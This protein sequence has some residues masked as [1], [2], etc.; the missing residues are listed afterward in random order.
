MTPGDAGRNGTRGLVFDVDTFAVHDGPGIRM[1]VYLKGCPL[2]C[3]WCHSPESRDP[4]RELV[5]YRDR[6]VG[7]G[8]CAGACPEHAHALDPERHTID[9][10]RCRACFA[11]AD[12]CPS[13]ALGVKGEL[14]PPGEIVARAARMRPFFEHSGGGVTL[15]GGKVTM[16]PGFAAAALEGCRSEGVHT[17]LETSG[18][19]A[20]DR[21]ER[22]VRLADL[23][24]YDIK[25]VDEDEHR[26]WTGAGNGPVL[27]NA[28]RLAVLARE[29][30]AEVEVRVPLIPGA[31]DTDGN[32]RGIFA[33]MR[34]AGLGR[35]TLLP[36]NASAGA[37]Y[38]WLGLECP[39][40]AEPQGP[41]RL[42]AAVALARNAGIEATV[43]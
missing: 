32:L 17:A 35:A 36:F 18:A 21:L 4:G 41:E 15:T 37:K 8:A 20:W 30:G 2:R 12:A 23:V 24:L 27:D 14:V 26:R 31:T 7:C 13:G 6:C 29:G 10:A 16:Q 34:D 40:R 38:E 25:L 33:F 42:V 43:G 28:R 9:R 22:L 5:F 1:A 39:V 3:A 19:C 11:C